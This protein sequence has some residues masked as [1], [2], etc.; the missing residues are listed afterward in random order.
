VN[1]PAVALVVLVIAEVVV[2][3]AVFCAVMFIDWWRKPQR[4]PPPKRVDPDRVHAHM[5]WS[6]HEDP[7]EFDSP[8][9]GNGRSA[10]DAISASEHE[11]QHQKEANE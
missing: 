3:I 11:E 2:V 8:R 6:W 1:H 5:S 4:Q 9:N 10:E 7:I